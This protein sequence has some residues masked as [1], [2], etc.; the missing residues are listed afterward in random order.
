LE[1]K[2]VA[3]SPSQMPKTEDDTGLAASTVATNGKVVCAIFATGDVICADMDGKQLWAKNIGIPDNPYG[4][5]SSLLILGN[6]LII[7]YDNRNAPKVLALDL[8]NGNTRWVKERP[9]R[10]PSWCSPILATVNDK[11]QLILVGNPGVTS[12]NPNN[13]EINWR[14]ECMS[15]EPAPSPAYSNG[16]VFTVTE[17][18][19]MTAINATDGS[20]LWKHSDFLPEISSPVATKDFVFVATSYGVVA[21]YDTQTGDLIHSMELNTDF[22]SSPIIADGKIYLVC[23]D[24]KVYIFSAKGDFSLI[25]SFETKEKTFATPAF[26]DRKVVVRT[27]KSLYCVGENG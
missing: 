25:N 3:G 4:Y 27:E 15:G 22:H 21:T 1:V 13:G 19:S 23:T 20:V 6:S 12:Y 7:Q 11:A 24:G 5:A 17:Y 8:T 14:V 10:N 16:I 26:T 18:A 9:E 2:N